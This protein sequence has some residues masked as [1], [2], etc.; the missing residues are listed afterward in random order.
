MMPLQGTLTCTLRPNLAGW[1]YEND[2]R[3]FYVAC[4]VFFTSRERGEQQPPYDVPMEQ[5]R[6]T[7]VVDG[8]GIH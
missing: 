3:R 4:I 7:G 5:I 2:G 8:H 1:G 6:G